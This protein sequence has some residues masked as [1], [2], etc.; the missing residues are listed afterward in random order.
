MKMDPERIEK[1]KDLEADIVIIGGGGA[2][3]D[4]G[5]IPAQARTRRGKNTIAESTGSAC[6]GLGIAL[7]TTDGTSR[8]S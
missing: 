3:Q 4:L 1:V 6:I 2:G 7:P 5:G 8:I